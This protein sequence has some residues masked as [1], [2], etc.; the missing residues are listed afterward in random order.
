MQ[1][2]G[3]AHKGIFREA[4][5]ASGTA[6]DGDGGGGAVTALMYFL[7]LNFLLL[8]LKVRGLHGS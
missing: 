5:A 1:R 7:P 3:D 6:G 2:Q 4:L 8:V